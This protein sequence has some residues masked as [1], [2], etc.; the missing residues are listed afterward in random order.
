MFNFI[1]NPEGIFEKENQELLI[2]EVREVSLLVQQVTNMTNTDKLNF[3]DK[4]HE[5]LENLWKYFYAI[6]D[7]IKVYTKDIVWWGEIAFNEKTISAIQKVQ[8]LESILKDLWK[9][10][11]NYTDKTKDF[12][13]LKNIESISLDESID[14]S[15]RKKYLNDY[16]SATIKWIKKLEW[17]KNYFSELLG[18]AWEMII[19]ETTRLFNEDW[20]LDVNEIQKIDIIKE[21][22]EWIEKSLKNEDVINKQLEKLFFIMKLAKGLDQSK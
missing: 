5:R 19:E 7:L 14:L 12:F 2:Q 20:V 17:F 4:N 15:R 16:H 13:S 3:L 11:Q 22:V 8:S 21:N 1:E 18:D 9:E 10:F 6:V